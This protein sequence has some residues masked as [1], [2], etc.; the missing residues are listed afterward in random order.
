[1]PNITPTPIPIIGTD[2]LDL[3]YTDKSGESFNGGQPPVFSQ[4]SDALTSTIQAKTQNEQI[5][6]PLDSQDIYTGRTYTV[7][8]STYYAPSTFVSPYKSVISAPDY[9]NPNNTYFDNPPK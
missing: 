5:L 8:N 4:P 6:T 1:M 7:Y 3:L 2:I 9:Y